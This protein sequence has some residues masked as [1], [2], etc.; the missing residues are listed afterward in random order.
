[1]INIK[2]ILHL[3]RYAVMKNYLVGRECVFVLTQLSVD[4]AA[5][6]YLFYF[7]QLEE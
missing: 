1:M 3:A 2:V 6:L 7:G 4:G 5:N